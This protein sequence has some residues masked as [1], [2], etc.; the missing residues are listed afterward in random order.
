[1]LAQSFNATLLSDPASI[2]T[3]ADPLKVFTLDTYDLLGDV[4]GDPQK[5]GFS[6]VTD[7]CIETPACVTASPSVQDTYLF[8]DE[9]HSDRGRAFAYGPARVRA[10]CARA[11]HL[12]DDAARLRRARFRRLARP[13]EDDLADLPG[14]GFARP[15]GSTRD[16]PRPLDSDHGRAATASSLWR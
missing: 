14:L 11:L 4:V 8:W 15:A 6:N 3:G 9:L 12:D 5:Y 1:M 10:R 7:E 13:P 2:E 16:T